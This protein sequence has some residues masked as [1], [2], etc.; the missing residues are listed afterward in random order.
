MTQ[1]KPTAFSRG[2]DAEDAAARLLARQGFDV[3]ARRVRTPRGEIDLIAR[4]GNLLLFVEVKARAG[5]R[6]AAESLL[7]RQRRRIAAAAEVY[8]AAHPELAG[9]DMR[10]DVVLLAP[11]R[12]PVHLPGAFEAE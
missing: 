12:A 10:L 5:L 4:R 9:L 7:L 6:A 8:L 3:L 11:G 1:P 2:M